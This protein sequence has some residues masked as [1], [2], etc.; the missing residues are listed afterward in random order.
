MIRRILIVIRALLS[1][2]GGFFGFFLDRFPL[3]PIRKTTKFS[4]GRLERED[5]S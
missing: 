1:T 2:D 5:I 3:F 4:V